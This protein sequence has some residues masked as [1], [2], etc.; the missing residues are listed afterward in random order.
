MGKTPAILPVPTVSSD[1]IIYKGATTGDLAA[2]FKMDHR[3]VR[4]KMVELKP[5]GRRG[6]SDVYEVAEAARLLVRPFD[7]AE[8]VERILK[9]N[10]TELPKM[11]SKE[12]WYAQTQKQKYELAAGDLWPTVE[13]VKTAG[14]AFKT[15]R[16]SLQLLPDTIDREANL[17]EKQRETVQRVIDA[18]LNDMRERLIHA[19][20]NR[21][22][23]SGGGS[24]S[25]EEDDGD[26]EL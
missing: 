11:L 6:A 1:P 13:I 19:F 18:A 22:I 8:I 20:E 26:E 17:S 5:C 10:H 24:E 2:M 23:S 12:F 21:R 25:P 15:L 9:M 14:E 4:S 3:L 7:D 16:L